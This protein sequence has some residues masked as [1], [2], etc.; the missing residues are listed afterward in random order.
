MTLLDEFRNSSNLDSF[1]Y[2]RTM[3]FFPKEEIR[4]TI[5]FLNENEEIIKQFSPKQIV[6][7]SEGLIEVEL[8][9]LIIDMFEVSLR[10]YPDNEE[11]ISRAALM[12]LAHEKWQQA[13]EYLDKLIWIQ[14]DKTTA[15]TFDLMVKALRCNLQPDRA[16]IFVSQ[17]LTNYPD[18]LD[19]QRQKLD[20]EI[21]RY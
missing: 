1:G 13:V 15:F 16:W 10:I 8:E 5:Q 17:G 4:F 11:I 19:L 21:L 9:E 20:L 3:R 7:I 2:A 6:G 12:S 14:G 18:N